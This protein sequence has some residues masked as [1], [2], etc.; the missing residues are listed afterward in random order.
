MRR[1][2]IDPIISPLVLCDFNV[3]S[4]RRNSLKLVSKVAESSDNV[5]YP[6]SSLAQEK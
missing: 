5:I 3:Y 4:L 1:R 2:R 6:S